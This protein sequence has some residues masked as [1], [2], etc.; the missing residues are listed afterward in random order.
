MSQK[1]R[2][3][4]FTAYTDW[5][6]QAWKRSIVIQFA[7]HFSRGGR[8]GALTP[9]HSTPIGIRMTLRKWSGAG[10]TR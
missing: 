10:G 2:K 1:G 4:Q 8:S 7:R 9:F 6:Q 3:R 5:H